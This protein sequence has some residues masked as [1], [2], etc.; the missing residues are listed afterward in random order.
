MDLNSEP[1]TIN[2]SLTYGESISVPLYLS[3]VV[4]ILM[5]MGLLTP[6]IVAVQIATINRGGFYYFYF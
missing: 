4:I 1:D 3:I 2:D 5:G 6:F